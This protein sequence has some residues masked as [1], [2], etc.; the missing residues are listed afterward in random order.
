MMRVAIPSLREIQ[1]AYFEYLF[2][3]FRGPYEQMKK[4]GVS[5]ADIAA[6]VASR[7]NIVRSFG[8]DADEFFGD[9]HAFWNRHREFV[10]SAVSGLKGL[11][12]TFGGD[13]SQSYVHNVATSTG[14]YTNIRGPI[15]SWS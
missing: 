15:S 6:D 13:L 3:W 8:T 1:S 7:E 5:C 4:H 2:R 14:L 11:K 10:D 9:L 12:A